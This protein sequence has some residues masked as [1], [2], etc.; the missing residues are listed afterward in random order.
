MWSEPCFPS[1]WHPEVA[2]FSNPLL[3]QHQLDEDPHSCTSHSCTAML[4][5]ALP[6]VEIIPL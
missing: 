3:R 2:H 4:Q 6:L 5:E 1:Q